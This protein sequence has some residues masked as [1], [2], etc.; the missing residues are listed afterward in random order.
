MLRSQTADGKARE[1]PPLTPLARPSYSDE[2]TWFPCSHGP[3][4][5]PV[6]IRSCPAAVYENDRRHHALCFGMGS[7]G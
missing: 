1:Y 6:R 2:C 3:R 7:D 4:G 5:N